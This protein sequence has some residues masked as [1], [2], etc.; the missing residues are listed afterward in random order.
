MCKTFTLS[1]YLQRNCQGYLRPVGRV[2]RTT[3]TFAKRNAKNHTFAQFLM[4][5]G[6][7]LPDDYQMIRPS[8][9]AMYRSFLKYDVGQPVVDPIAWKLACTWTEK[10]YGNVMGAS[11]VWE[12]DDSLI[13]MDKTT[14]PGF[15]ANLTF[16]KKSSVLMDETASKILDDYWD[17]IGTDNPD[18]IIP[19]WK[20]SQKV[21]M[22]SREKVVGGKIRTFTCAPIELGLATIRLCGDQNEKMND[23]NCLNENTTSFIGASKYHGGWNRLAIKL[24][25]HPHLFELDE[26]NYDSSLFQDVFEFIFEFRWKCLAKKFRTLENYRRLKAVYSS[27]VFSWCVLEDGTIFEKDTGNPS[28]GNNTINDNTLALD[29]F[30][31]YAW[32]VS[33]RASGKPAI[34]ENFKANVVAVLNG[35]DN[36]YCCSDEALEIIRPSVVTEIW[37]KIGIVTKTPSLEPRPLSSTQFLS[38]SFFF[39]EK[40]KKWVPVPEGVKVICSLLVASSCDDV[41]WHYLRACALR[42]ES[43]WNVPIRDLL[44]EYICHLTQKHSDELVG[45]IKGLKFEHIKSSYFTDSELVQLYLGHESSIRDLVPRLAIFDL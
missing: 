13:W 11:E 34:Y 14:S 33:C 24:L 20:V 18:S 27:I 15:P 19:L 23:A 8:R 9:D 30:F 35:D 39:H 7:E 31:N 3:P 6:I 44:S 42:I 29:C 21:E 41:R 40:F 37:S 43:F 45:E 25:T 4:N 5:R 10:T 26:S 16:D 17:V 38:T 36:T 1:N 12:K 32:I 2:L 28:G 22:R